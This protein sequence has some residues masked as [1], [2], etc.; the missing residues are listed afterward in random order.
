MATSRATQA[1]QY[2][3]AVYQFRV[4]VGGLTLGFAEVSGLQ[5]EHQTI[6]YRHG[7]SFWEGEAISKFH[8]DKFMPMTLKKGVMKADDHAEMLRWLEDPG[9]RSLLVSLCDESGNAVL[10]WKVAKALLTKIEAPNLVAA[11]NDA[12]IDT[13]HLMVSG[14]MVEHV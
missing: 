8:L 2:P 6:T 10:N 5:R 4:S 7:L 12:A 13:L 1:A 11:G 3:L 9:P 14:V